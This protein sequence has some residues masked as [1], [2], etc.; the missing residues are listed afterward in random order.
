MDASSSLTSCVCKRRGFSPLRVRRTGGPA[1]FP[2]R[3]R[4]EGQAGGH[5]GYAGARHVAGSAL[6]ATGDVRA[7]PPPAA[8][9]AFTKDRPPQGKGAHRASAFTQAWG[10]GG[11]PPRPRLTV[12]QHTHRVASGGDRLTGAKDARSRIAALAL[13]C[14][15]MFVLKPEGPSEAAGPRPAFIKS[16]RRGDGRASLSGGV[17]TGAGTRASPARLLRFPE[18]GAAWQRETSRSWARKAPHLCCVA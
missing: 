10:P 5:R 18:S 2:S 14:Q 4:R 17:C 6:G 13:G 11:D 7:S 3:G 12:L 16:R 9:I 1:A 15:P 8:Q